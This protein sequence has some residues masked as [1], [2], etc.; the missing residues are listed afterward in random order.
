MSSHI[1]QSKISIILWIPKVF[2]GCPRLE[3]D[4]MHIQILTIHNFYNVSWT[5]NHLLCVTKCR[6]C[7]T[8]LKLGRLFFSFLKF[9]FLHGLC[10]L[11]L[12]IGCPMLFKVVSG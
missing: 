5:Y 2:Q 11:I 9:F 6:I 1:G 8:I 3:G 12:I 4:N 7:L 10:H